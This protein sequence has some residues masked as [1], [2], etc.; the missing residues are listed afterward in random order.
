M[1]L[2]R[3][4]T[5]GTRLSLL[6]NLI[7]REIAAEHTGTVVKELGDGLFV[8]F[9]DPVSACLAAIDIKAAFSK[10]REY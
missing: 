10:K 2:S 3:G 8:E 9:K 6:H 1:K 7:C 4:H 5:Y